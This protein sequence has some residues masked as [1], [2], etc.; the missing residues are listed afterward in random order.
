M[1]GNFRLTSRVLSSLSIPASLLNLWSHFPWFRPCHPNGAL[2]E[3]HPGAEYRSGLRVR[4]L[5]QKAWV[6]SRNGLSPL[7]LRGKGGGQEAPPFKGLDA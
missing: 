6:P 5:R 1:K 4:A 7:G 3:L 2:Q